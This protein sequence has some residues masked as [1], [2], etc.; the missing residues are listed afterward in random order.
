MFFS[1]TLE[2]QGLKFSTFEPG[3]ISV[4]SVFPWL[5]YPNIFPKKK[6]YYAHVRGACA[7]VCACAHPQNRRTVS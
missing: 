5:E 1:E 3:L 2:V 7:P 4:E 6:P